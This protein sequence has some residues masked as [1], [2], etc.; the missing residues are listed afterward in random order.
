MK[1]T[2][3]IALDEKTGTHYAC[4]ELR[5]DEGGLMFA[6]YGGGSRAVFEIALKRFGYELTPMDVANILL[7]SPDQ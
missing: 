2:E 1:I 7:A 3:S 6:C 4:Y 5:N